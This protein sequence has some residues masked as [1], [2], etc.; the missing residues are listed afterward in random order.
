[1]ELRI[2]DIVRIT[3]LTDWQV[4]T[5]IFRRMKEAPLPIALQLSRTLDVLLEVWTGNKEYK[6]SH[7]S[8]EARE[9]AKAYDKAAAKDKTMVRMALDLPL[10]E[11]KK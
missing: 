8:V 5:I 10:M 9:V 7:I 1:M 2:S 4:C 11:E 6:T 3:G